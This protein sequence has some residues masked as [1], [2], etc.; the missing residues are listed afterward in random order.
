MLIALRFLP[1]VRASVVAGACLCILTTASNSAMADFKV[2]S[3]NIDYREVEI[4]NNTS[5]TFDKRPENNN[6][7]SLTQE[8]GVGILPFWTVELEGEFGREP[9]EKW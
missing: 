2:R 1:N 7:N 3:P 5:T 8:I 9:S 6:R 4:E